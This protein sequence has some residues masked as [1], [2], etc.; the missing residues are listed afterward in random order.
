MNE[1]VGLVLEAHVGATPGH[2]VACGEPVRVVPRVA[3]PLALTLN[4]LGANALKHGALS[5][6][7]GTIRI[8]WKRVG[9]D[10]LEITWVESH[11]HHASEPCPAGTGS[12][13][14]RGLVQYELN[15]TLDIRHDANGLDCR[16][17][18]PV[19]VPDT[20]P[21]LASDMGEST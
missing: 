20:A 15:G 4:E 14:M 1:L 19:A 16:I 8:D 10:G 5:G 7:D 6:R 9:N 18:I 12:L 21:D 11:P 3:A 2:I 13:L 17:V